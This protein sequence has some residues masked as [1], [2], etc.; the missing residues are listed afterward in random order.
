MLVSGEGLGS[1][2]GMVRLLEYFHV[3][4]QIFYAS[5]RLL[6]FD[7]ESSEEIFMVAIF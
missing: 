3:W 1:R 2:Y 5:A 6:G 7:L 4:D